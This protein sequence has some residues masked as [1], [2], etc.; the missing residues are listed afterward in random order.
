MT[1]SRQ[2]QF[3]PCAIGERQQL[4][5]GWCSRNLRGSDDSHSGILCGE[6]YCWSSQGTI[7]DG[8]LPRNAP[9][10]LPQ[11]TNDSGACTPPTSLLR[12]SHYSA[13]PFPTNSTQIERVHRMPNSHS[14]HAQSPIQWN[15][16]QLKWHRRCDPSMTKTGPSL[17][18]SR[19]PN[20]DWTRNYTENFLVL[21]VELGNQ[22]GV[23]LENPSL[24]WLGIKTWNEPRSPYEFR[25]HLKRC[26]DNATRYKS[27][28]SMTQPNFP[29]LGN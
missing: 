13:S 3:N 4:Y 18:K 9:L 5:R 26:P 8:S 22:L 10:R 15:C 6:S 12:A 19:L 28:N 16:V 14:Q 24:S 21:P 27:G 25:N 2:K 23:L 11:S 7:T 1:I 29:K 20:K 17:S